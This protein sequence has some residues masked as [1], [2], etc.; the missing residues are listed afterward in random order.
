[1]PSMKRVL[2]C[3]RCTA[4][5]YQ[6]IERKC[7]TAHE[8]HTSYVRAM[9]AMRSHCRKHSPHKG[10]AESTQAWSSIAPAPMF[11]ATPA[12]AL[13]LRRHSQGFL[14]MK[15]FRESVVSPSFGAPSGSWK[16]LHDGG[17]LGSKN[18]PT[19]RLQ[20]LL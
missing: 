15:H 18:N 6:R 13:L 4:H 19:W 11:G 7:R 16:L 10:T 14:S 9:S 2:P 12:E 3:P 1:M 20:L 17:I 5:P 8:K